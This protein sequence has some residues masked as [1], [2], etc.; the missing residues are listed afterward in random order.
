MALMKRAPS[1][2]RAAVPAARLQLSAFSLAPETFRGPGF[3]FLHAIGLSHHSWEAT[4][5]R[6]AAHGPAHALTLAGFGESDFAP[7]DDYSLRAQAERVLTG[8]RAAGLREWIL[9]GNSLGGAV[10]L[11]AALAAPAESVGLVL[12]NPAAYR[13]GLPWVGRL[14][15]LP[16]M[17]HVLRAVPSW[18]LRAGL[19]IGSGSR[20]WTTAAH[21]QRCQQAFRRRGG[22]RAF[23]LSLRALYGA[24][25]AAL[26]RRY[27]EVTAPTL[28]LRGERDWLVPRWVTQRL[29]R[30]LPNAR[31]V[32]L[33][34]LGH[35]PQEEDPG[36]IAELCL[37]F[38]RERVQG[39]GR[40]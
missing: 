6:V 31:L 27:P 1:A 37:E 39:D 17:H 7:D 25:L 11:A 35:F 30:A 14:G 16:G 34:N 40:S 22:S 10:A 28:L 26:E 18:S 5:R 12:A 33:P 3:V 15:L 4:A 38:A 23:A 13:Q 24:E 19:V 20:G 2:A 21:G 8:V 32:P 29:A 36:Q 9:V